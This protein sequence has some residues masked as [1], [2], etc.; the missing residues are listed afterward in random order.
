MTGA[1][2]EPATAQAARAR[3]ADADLRLFSA[4]LRDGCVSVASVCKQWRGAWR[5]R[6]K[7][8]AVRFGVGDFAYG[9]H[10]TALA[11]GGVIVPVYARG[12]LHV[13]NA[14]G[15]LRCC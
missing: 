13:F 14:E 8:S 10:L 7:A 15:E 4:P 11:G 9:D 12:V 5:L 6:A 2:A 1:R 3:R